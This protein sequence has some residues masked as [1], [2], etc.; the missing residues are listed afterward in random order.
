MPVTDPVREEKFDLVVEETAESSVRLSDRLRGE[1]AANAELHQTHPLDILGRERATGL[2]ADQTE[3][4][5]LAQARHRFPGDIAQLLDLHIPHRRLKSYDVGWLVGCASTTTITR[6]PNAR[7]TA[8]SIP[9]HGHLGRAASGKS[10]PSARW[11]P[12]QCRTRRD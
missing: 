1:S 9:P 4:P 8:S 10:S 11:V 2:G 12:A 5:P 3:G 7:T 6:R